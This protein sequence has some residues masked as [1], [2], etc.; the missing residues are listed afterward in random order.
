MEASTMILNP[1]RRRVPMFTV[2]ILA[3]AG[4]TVGSA[5]AATVTGSY[6]GVVTNT[7]A[8]PMNLTTAG[9]LDWAIWSSSATT[10]ASTPTNTKSGGPG[11]IGPVTG[12][13]GSVINVKGSTLY[14]SGSD[15][16][17][18]TNFSAAQTRGIADGTLNTAGSGLSFT[19]K[20]TPGVMEEVSIYVGA[21]SSNIANPEATV[22][23]ASLAGATTYT[24]SAPLGSNNDFS[25]QGAIYTVDFMPDSAS[26]LLTITYKTTNAPGPSAQVLLSAVAVSSVTAVPVPAALSGGLVIMAGLVTRRRSGHR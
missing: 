24:H 26:D 12:L 23:T 13:S 1:V 20:G 25:K 2:A 6:S 15:G 10:P 18:P 5:S 21:Y 3:A 11:L 8:T 14:F 4:L 19:I 16:T 22:F 17:S 9:T 7:A